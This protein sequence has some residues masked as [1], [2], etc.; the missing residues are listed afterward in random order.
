MLMRD[1]NNLRVFF[2]QFAPG[3]LQ[4]Q[5]GSE[6][7]DLY[8][9][10]E[11]SPETVLTGRFKTVERKADLSGVFREINDAKTSEEARR[12]R[13]RAHYSAKR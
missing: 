4:T 9:R 5:Y 10:G 2:G 12:E 11:L 7:W 6:I 3:L 13:L 1:I 8:Q